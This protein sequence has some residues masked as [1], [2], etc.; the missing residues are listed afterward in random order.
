MR[1]FGLSALA[2]VFAAVHVYAEQHVVHFD[3]RCERGTPTL[4]QGGKVL[5][6]G[7]DYVSKG[8]LRSAIAYLQTG[9]LYL[10]WRRL[11]S[12]RN[13]ARKFNMPRLRLKQGHLF[14]S[15]AQVLSG[16]RLSLLQGL[17]RSWRLLY[18]CQL[19]A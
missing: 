10:Q 7:K 5:L 3:N 19:P 12:P 17:R 8:P 2:T 14:D 1:L 15:S 6:T 11:H 4:I 18:Q 9:K 16:H 13:Y